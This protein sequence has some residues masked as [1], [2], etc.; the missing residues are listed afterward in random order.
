MFGVQLDGVTDDTAAFEAL[1]LAAAASGQ[2]ISL[3][4]GRAKLTRQ[5]TVPANIAVTYGNCV[6][7]FTSVSRVSF[8]DG[9]CV[10]N[11][12]ETPTLISPLAADVAKGD[13]KSRSLRRRPW[14]RAMSS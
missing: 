10:Q 8:P 4:S 11:F 2:M 14:S 1:M 12:G 13:V 7:D 9:A 6:L 5:I 3:G